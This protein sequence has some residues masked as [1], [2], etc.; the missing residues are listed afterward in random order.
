MYDIA[1][2]TQ[3]IVHLQSHRIFKAKS[4]PSHGL[5]TPAMTVC[6]CWL[7]H[8][9]MHAP[10]LPSSLFVCGPKTALKN[11]VYKTQHPRLSLNGVLSKTSVFLFIFKP[12][13]NLSGDCVTFSPKHCLDIQCS[14]HLQGPPFCPRPA[15]WLGSVVEVPTG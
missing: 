1:M 2:G 5:W 10:C 11:E 14:Q 7:S 8:R 9:D 15:L 4:K 6:E 13:Q 12:S 3:V